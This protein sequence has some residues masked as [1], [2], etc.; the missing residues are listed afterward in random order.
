M[1]ESSGRS[2]K[3]DLRAGENALLEDSK[4]A[5]PIYLINKKTERWLDYS[6]QVPSWEKYTRY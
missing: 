1:G 6:V 2:H 3:N 4:R 5:Q